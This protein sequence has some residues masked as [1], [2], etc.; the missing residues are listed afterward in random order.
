MRRISKLV[1]VLLLLLAVLFGMSKI[2]SVLTATDKP[3]F[4]LILLIVS[5][6][7]IGVL[8]TIRKK[9]IPVCLVFPFMI[10]FLL[11]LLIISFS[12]DFIVILMG[13]VIGVIV[14]LSGTIW[15]WAIRPT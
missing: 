14:G 9:K 8:I 6:L 10:V 3:I 13:C 7:T 12:G 2:W 1:I 4:A 11:I 5:V 15:K